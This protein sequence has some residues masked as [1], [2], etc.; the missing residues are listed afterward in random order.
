MS[1]IEI[2]GV[3]FY[4]T[5]R[6]CIFSSEEYRGTSNIQSADSSYAV[7]NNVQ[8][9]GAVCRVYYLPASHQVQYWQHCCEVG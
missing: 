9:N 4:I 1:K 8:I 5:S 7:F 6:R 2:Q 3:T